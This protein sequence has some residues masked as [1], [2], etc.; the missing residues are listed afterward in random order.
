MRT[1]QAGLLGWAVRTDRLDDVARRLGLP[2]EAGSR[3][4]RGGRLLR[5]R[6][7]GIERAAGEPSL[8]FFI[9]WG[10][11]IP[12]PG[13]APATH[14]GGAMQIASLQL[15]GD[16]DRVGAWLGAHSLPITVRTGAPA[17]AGVVLRGA[18]GEL[19]LDADGL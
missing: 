9:E 4:V 13:R 12:L 3:V 18:T 8:P 5:W 16:A 14:L 11:G 19:V 1:E 10:G 17:L 2:I 6:S 15:E 7:A